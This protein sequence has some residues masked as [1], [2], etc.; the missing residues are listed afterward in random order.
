MTSKHF[1]SLC[2][3]NVTHKADTMFAN[4]NILR[5]YAVRLV[6]SNCQHEGS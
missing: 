2:G 3:N 4:S 5:N 6:N 1:T